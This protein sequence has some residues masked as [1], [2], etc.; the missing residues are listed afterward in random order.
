M[1]K[2]TLITGVTGQDGAYLS[3]FLLDKGYEVFGTYRRTSTPNFWRLC[4]L[5]ILNKVKLIPSD[6]TDMASLLEAVTISQPD[7]IYNLAAQSFVSASFEKPLLTADVDALGT[8]R[9][10]EVIRLLNPK[11]RFYQ[12]SSSEV[13]G[14]VA[15]PGTVIDESTPMHPASP[16][17]AAKLYSYHA[18]R[19]YREAYGLFASN[20]LLFNHE[21]PLRG[22]EFVTRKVTNAAA[23]IR[24]GLSDHLD[25]GNLD[26]KRDWGYAPE[27]VEAMWMMLQAPAPD[28]FIV[29]TKATH[30]VRELLEVA[31]GELDLDWQKYVKTD[32][33]FLR[34]LD[35][36]H[37]L[38]D[39][40]KAKSKL[41]W[42]PKTSFKE[43]IRTMVQA[44]H[45]RWS[46]YRKGEVFP[47]DAPNYPDEA[48][49][50]TRA[51]KT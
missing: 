10:L 42:E 16:Y 41:G 4:A 31:F 49:I 26:A 35:V 33:R 1:A 11:V 19:I 50:I 15:K 51:L 32:K 14:N 29:A 8:T 27:Y 5:G 44:D 38:G 43:L 20:G 28:D 37:L 13:F 40:S 17:A 18:T 21:S 30:S 36:Q 46:R 23:Q 24:L 6:V 34:P 2:R 25:L 7:E 45:D 48:I 12:A 39:S 22:L 3:A 47:W 9:L